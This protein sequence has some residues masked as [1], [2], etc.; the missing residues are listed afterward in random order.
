MTLSYP[1]K[2]DVKEKNSP[3]PLRGDMDVVACIQPRLSPGGVLV[4]ATSVARPTQLMVPTRRLHN[5]MVL[6]AFGSGSYASID[7]VG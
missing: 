4:L 1:I 2:G 6:D 3:P 7:S 5:A